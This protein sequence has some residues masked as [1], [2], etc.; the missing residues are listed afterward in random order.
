MYQ[1]TEL[2][3]IISIGLVWLVKFKYFVEHDEVLL[4]KLFPI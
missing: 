3:L 2:I 4:D 1:K